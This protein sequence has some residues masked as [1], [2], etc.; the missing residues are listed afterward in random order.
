MATKPKKASELNGSVNALAD[1]FRGVISEAFEPISD[2]L[3]EESEKTRKD[4]NDIR[5]DI[6]GMRKHIDVV[7]KNTQAQ[8]AEVRKDLNR[9]EI[10][11]L[12]S[13]K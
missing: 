6:T 7:A 5:S 2:L 10:M 3:V 9:S 11:T 4:I 8:I 12:T 13:C 1:A